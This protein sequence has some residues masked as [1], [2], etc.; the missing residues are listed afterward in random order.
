MTVKK[1]EMAK[2]L[3]RIMVDRGFLE[4]QELGL[5][6]AGRVKPTF[7]V[8]A[9]WRLEPGST[10][11]PFTVIIRDAERQRITIKNISV[12]PPPDEPIPPF[13]QD[14]DDP[15]TQRTWTFQGSIQVPPSIFNR[16]KSLLFRAAIKY[17]NNSEEIME[18]KRC[19]Q[20]YVAAEN[21][22]LKKSNKWYYGDTHYHSIY[23]NDIKEFG[24]PVSD[25]RAAAKCIG[26][27]W[28][29]IT[30]HSVDLDSH[31]PYG[32]NKR[33]QSRWDDLGMEVQTNSD[34]DFCIL[35]GEE[36]SVRGKKHWFF[37][38][39]DTLHLLVF[40]TRFKKMIPGAWAEEK[41][42]LNKVKVDLV[43]FQEELYRHLFGRIY[44]LKDVLTGKTNEE[45][46]A[47]CSVE[48]Q[49]ALA[50]AAHPAS[51]A[52]FLGSKWGKSDLSQ[53]IHGLEAWNTRKRLSCGREECPYEIW[54]DEE[55]VD[56]WEGGPNDKGIESWDKLL[57]KK[58]KLDN[59]RF[60]L[61]AGSDAHG[62][63]NFSEGWGYDWDGIKASDNALGKVRTLIFLPQR[64]PGEP[65]HAPSEDEIEGA[66]RKGSLVVTDGPVLNFKVRYGEQEA[67]LGDIMT[68]NDEGVI[69]LVVQAAWTE[70][71]GS[72]E[73]ARVVY[74]FKNGLRSLSRQTTVMRGEQKILEDKLPS[75]PGY[76]RL[77][78]E[79][80]N[81]K[82]SYRCFT[83][84]I[85][86]KSES[87]GKRRL[88]IIFEKQNLNNLSEG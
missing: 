4:E 69:E 48:E 18:E 9:P 19:L 26:L 75:G 72:I 17:K 33:T 16:S 14:L 6:A 79:T 50:F 84:P 39:D 45:N 24:N 68:V 59:P 85:W 44:R 3:R 61:L 11:I 37:L 87:S 56:E 30:D 13:T 40:G 46:L 67:N 35:R 12:F 53:S 41:N 21:L 52:Q 55:A 80:H 66:I 43:G 76:I 20:I 25:T 5:E 83:N 57:R 60:I 51:D 8:D 27:D 42:L 2:F 74:H 15:L 62:S 70:E 32:E 64:S 34:D 86:I 7:W 36:V 31:N 23:T 88:Q 77:E 81:G 63:F 73:K 28:L 47:G 58:V 65:R 22:P 49:S 1:K 78:T 29:I 38:N 71:C 82:D 10:E 54:K